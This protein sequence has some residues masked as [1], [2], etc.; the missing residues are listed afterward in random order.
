V[1]LVHLAHYPAPYPGSFVPMLGAAIRAARDRGWNVEVVLGTDA[2][3][4]PWLGDLERAGAP[5]RLFELD[6]RRELGRAVSSLL[7]E[8]A[9]PTILHT[10]FTAFDVPAAL[11]ARRRPH[12]AVVWHLHSPAR[13]DLVGRARGLAKS[14]LAGRLVDRILC[15]SP[16]RAKAAIAQGA[17]RS[18]VR[19]FPNAIDVSAY[20]VATGEER[21][22]AREALGLAPRGS[23]LLHFGWDWHRKGGD[24]FLEAVRLLRSRVGDLTAVTVGADLAAA[25]ADGVVV[26]PVGSRVQT[27][28]AAADVFASPSRAEGMP[29][30]VLEALASGVPVA[31]SDI[32]GQTAV[33]RGLGACRL[34]P[35]EPAALAGAI[36]ALLDRDPDTAG[37]DRAE[38]VKRVRTEYDLGPW[39]RRLLA[40]YDE[41]APAT[42]SR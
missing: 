33:G 1:R 3:G 26:L 18:R 4:C 29:F 22:A 24:V 10:H 27:L 38:A 32:P 20:I 6:G 39:A 31:A 9:D 8:S 7:G 2:R 13:T 41:I 12:T 15:V 17:P 11:A 23:V 5:V 14:G 36:A 28:Y 37:R 40:V 30:A 21:L 35:L 25:A 42:S 34:V 19:F 16:D